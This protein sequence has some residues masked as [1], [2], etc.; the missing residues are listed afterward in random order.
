MDIS[1][2]A[3]SFL[4]RA[5]KIA[6]NKDWQMLASQALALLIEMCLAEAGIFFPPTRHEDQAP[7]AQKNEPQM[8]SRGRPNGVPE[9]WWPALRK[10]LL[11]LNLFQGDITRWIDR[12]TAKSD[13]AIARIFD[14]LNTLN[15]IMAL[16]APSLKGEGGGFLLINTSSAAIDMGLATLVANRLATDLEKAIDLEYNRQR[17]SRLMELNDILGQLGTS[18]NPDQV[19]RIFIERARQFLQVEAVSL[20]LIDENTGELVLQMASQADANVKV[21]QVR[22]PPGT[23]IIGR[24][25]MTGETLLVEDVKQDKRHYQQ[26]D[27]SSGFTT[28]SILAVPLRTRSIDLG[29]GRGMSRERIIGGLEAINKVG[30]FFLAEDV[31]LLQRLANGAATILVVA[32]LYV[33]ANNMFFDVVQAMANATDARGP[34]T[35]GHSQRVSDYAAEMARGLGLSSDDIYRVRLG[36]L[37]HDVNKMDMFGKLNTDKLPGGE[38][39]APTP[40]TETDRLSQEAQP[41]E[42]SMISRI[43]AVA[44]TFDTMASSRSF[45]PGMPVEEVFK[46]LR[47]NAEGQFDPRC[48]EALVSAHEKGLIAVSKSES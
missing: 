3:L 39:F 8:L 24:V 47:E 26:I 13:P 46:F 27:Q 18:L 20:F 12:D 34:L 7:G 2:K 29:H 35:A 43:F 40:T 22:V 6:L 28:R 15:N 21:E 45:R 38:I 11:Q 25:T 33:D 1:P 37:F 19:L 42:G 36:S 4:E 16:P 32:G 41:Q 5:N 14:N 48:V 10:K 30:G 31:E 23:G 9:A 44:D 17:E